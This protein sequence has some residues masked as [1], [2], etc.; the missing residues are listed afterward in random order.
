MPYNNLADFFLRTTVYNTTYATLILIGL[1]L[2]AL[3]L[4]LRPNVGRHGR[5]LGSVLL[6]FLGVTLC[7]PGWLL[8]GSTDFAFVPF[9]VALLMVWFL[10]KLSVEERMLWL[11]LGVPLLLALRHG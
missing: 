7:Q 2:V 11:W 8:L 6:L 10:P 1:T 3:I 5:I 4:A 9:L